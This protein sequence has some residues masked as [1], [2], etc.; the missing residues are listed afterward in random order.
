M[1]NPSDSHGTPIPGIGA[2]DCEKLS[3]G[4]GARCDW[5]PGPGG[6]SFRW[7]G[8]STLANVYRDS[9]TTVVDIS[10]WKAVRPETSSDGPGL[11][12]R[13]WPIFP[14]ISRY[15]QTRFS[16]HFHGGRGGER[17]I[18]LSGSA[19]VEILQVIY[20]LRLSLA[21][22]QEWRVAALPS[23]GLAGSA[24]LPWRRRPYQWRL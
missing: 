23:N 13:I 2:A 20:F 5:S 3:S 9:N 11:A 18:Y 7:A 16:Q 17:G 10:F 1:I 22:G 21:V 4:R 24:A 6:R 14:D 12:S 15:F 8:L 19:A